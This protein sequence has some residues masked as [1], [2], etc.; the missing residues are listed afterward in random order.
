M[1]LLILSRKFGGV[2][3]GVEKMVLLL[4]QQMQ[5]R[6]H[7]VTLVSLD[8]PEATPFYS[9]PQGVRWVKLGIGN[10][11]EKAST[12][13]RFSRIL[14]IR[15]L[16]NELEIDAVVGFQIG[17]FALVRFATIGTGVRSIAAER[18]APTLFDFI[19]NG[20]LKRFVS[21]A[22]LSLAS[23]VSVQLMENKKLYPKWLRSRIAVNPNPI[24][25]VKIQD[26]DKNH[27]RTQ[28]IILYVGRV[29]FQKN[30]EVLVRAI[31]LLDSTPVLRIV[32]EGDELEYIQSLANAEK[33]N[34][35]LFKFTDDL[36]S[37][38]LEA[39]IFC[40][41]SRWE[42]FP[43]V[44]GEALAHGLPVV[45]FAE[46]A[47]IKSLVR[48]FENGVIA[49]GNDNAISLSIALNLALSKDWDTSIIRNSISEFSL[50]SFA[51]TWE[52][53]LFPR[54]KDE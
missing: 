8:F 11:D 10:P 1:N 3:G 43:N 13:I 41:P 31:S 2:V 36:K 40:L 39:D 9:F 35:E 42:G 34:L 38:Y 52:S 21:F 27:Q 16:I 51:D 48:N 14:A 29:T 28:K 22:I 26:K 23:V 53:T 44:V 4:A 50:Q 49:D 46:C 15:R 47:G 24:S 30:L 18:N 32:G 19:R 12:N 33:V 45:G 20:R 25:T 37:L 7:S 17:S 54:I 5:L 6:G